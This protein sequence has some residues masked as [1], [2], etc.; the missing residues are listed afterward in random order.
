MNCRTLPPRSASNCG[1]SMYWGIPRPTRGVMASIGRQ[2]S[3][4]YCRG[5]CRPFTHSG[6]PAIMSRRNNLST[7]AIGGLLLAP[8]F[9]TAQK[10]AQTPPPPQAQSQAQ[11]SDSGDAVFSSETRLVPLNVTVMDKGGHLLT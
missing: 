7:L 9:V 3:N 6:E 4:W 1:T 5:D 2:M 11:A 10:P 8:F